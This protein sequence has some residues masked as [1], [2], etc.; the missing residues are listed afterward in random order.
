[1]AQPRKFNFDAYD[2]AFEAFADGF[3]LLDRDGD[4]DLY[5]PGCG[6]DD[7]VDFRGEKLRP[8]FNEGGEPWWM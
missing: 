5:I 6:E 4:D 3:D 2:D 7:T 1:M 8:R